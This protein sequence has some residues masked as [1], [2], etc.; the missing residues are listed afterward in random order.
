[1]ADVSNRGEA[2]VEHFARHRRASQRTLRRRFRH[3]GEDQ[4][5]AR[6]IFRIHPIQ[7]VGVAV[8][9]AGEH[10]QPSEIEKRGVFRCAGFDGIERADLSN[11]ISFDQ[12]A[13]IYP[14][15][16]RANVE[17]T[18]DPDERRPCRR[19]RANGN[20]NDKEQR[21]RD[22]Q[23]PN[24]HGRSLRSFCRNPSAPCR[25]PRPEF[26]STGRR[27]ASGHGL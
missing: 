22:H 14:I 13:L 25:V 6:A 9:Q 17:K 7:Q 4:I 21:D 5:V 15:C 3:D 27:I 18:A 12:D 26:G 16:S 10:R 1:V 19:L 23:T 24:S 11:A 8:N 20:D 2:T